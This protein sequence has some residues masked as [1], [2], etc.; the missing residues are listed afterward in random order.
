MRL[1]FSAAMLFLPAWALAEAPQ[2]PPAPAAVMGPVFGSSQF[3]PGGS[4]VWFFAKPGRTLPAG[5]MLKTET[6]SYC[7]IFLSDGTKLRLGPRANLRLTELSAEKSEMALGSG[8]LEAWVKKR[9]NAEFKAQT[10]L[11]TAALAEGIFA[12]E[13]LSPT[14]ATFDIFTGEPKILDSLGKAQTVSPGNRVEFDSKTGASTPAPLPSAA[15][16]PEE[17]SLTSPAKPASV[18]EPATAAAPA[19]PKK[20]AVKAKPAVPAVVKSTAT[21]A[22]APSKP[23]AAPKKAEPPAPDKSAATGLDTQL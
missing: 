17:P 1:I 23:E 5:S 4:D 9:E 21:A 13:V 12:A 14:S 3:Q 19:A 22:P 2:T 16:R 18:K 20:P 10:P 11:F 8:R 7:L 15:Q 6:G